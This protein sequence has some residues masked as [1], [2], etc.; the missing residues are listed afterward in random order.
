MEQR[1]D[2]TIKISKIVRLKF[3][4]TSLNTNYLKTPTKKSI[5]LK[6]KPKFYATCKKSILNIETQMS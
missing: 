2:G 5:R 4:H 6:S 3:N 1:R